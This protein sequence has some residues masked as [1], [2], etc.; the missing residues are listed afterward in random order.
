MDNNSTTTAPGT[1]ALD[2]PP[3]SKGYSLHIGLNKADPKH[4]GPMPQLK[5][6]IADAT[7]WHRYAHELGYQCDILT[8]EDATAEAVKNKIAEQASRLQ[9]GDIFLLTYA[10]HGGLIPNEKPAGF[11]NERNDQTWCLYDR[12]LL[13]DEL[14]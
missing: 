14:Y 10:G 5:A 7:F 8:D 2:V 4:Y 1:T 9:P 6:A 3:T 13:D 11:D 12:Q